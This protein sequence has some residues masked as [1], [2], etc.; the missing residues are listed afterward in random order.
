MPVAGQ[1]VDVMHGSNAPLLGRIIQQQMERLRTGDPVTQ[2]IDLDD[3]VPGEDM[4]TLRHWHWMDGLCIVI[5]AE[6]E[7][8]LDLALEKQ[9]RLSKELSKKMENKKLFD[10]TEFALL[11]LQ[12]YVHQDEDSLGRVRAL[13]AEAGLEVTAECEARL[14]EDEPRTLLKNTGF[15]D[16]CA[17]LNGHPAR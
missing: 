5:V 8:H 16:Q 17:K 10:E 14:E 1:P 4:E 9:E 13:V 12:E 3:A 15:E 6:S 7:L 2:P 11:Y